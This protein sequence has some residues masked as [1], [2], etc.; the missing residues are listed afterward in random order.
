[1]VKIT[2]TNFEIFLL[3]AQD[4]YKCM[5]TFGGKILENVT[6]CAGSCYEL[7]GIQHLVLMSTMAMVHLYD[8]Y[9]CI[10]YHVSLSLPLPGLLRCRLETRETQT[11]RTSAWA[12]LS[13]RWLKHGMVSENQQGKEKKCR[14]WCR[15]ALG[16]KPGSVLTG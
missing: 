7:Y 10:L 15:T 5:C 16:L 14:V 6:L 12:D 2:C 11:S 9:R 13:G 4:L 8:I 3:T 1:M